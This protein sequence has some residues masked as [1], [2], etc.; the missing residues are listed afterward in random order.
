LYNTTDTDKRMQTN[1]PTLLHLIL[2]SQQ[3]W[4]LL[5]TVL[6]I[7]SLHWVSFFHFLTAF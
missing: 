7:A 3:F 4:Q 1:H 2:I 5:F 6:H